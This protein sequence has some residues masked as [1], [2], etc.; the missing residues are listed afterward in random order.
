MESDHGSFAYYRR[1]RLPHIQLSITRTKTYISTM[2]RCMNTVHSRVA[3]IALIG[4]ASLL[5]VF[6]LLLF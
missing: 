5:F 6:P 4:L 1:E 3:M 2:C